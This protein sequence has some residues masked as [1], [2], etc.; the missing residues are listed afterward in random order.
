MPLT[1]RL[2]RLQEHHF[3]GLESQHESE[4]D[5][6]RGERKQCDGRG[7]QQEPSDLHLITSPPASVSSRFNDCHPDECPLYQCHLSPRR[8]GRTAVD[9]QALGQTS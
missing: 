9:G 3:S 4:E 1:L 7:S 6:E 8:M 2:L 5:V